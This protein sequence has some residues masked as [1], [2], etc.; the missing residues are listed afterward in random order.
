MSVN[1]R[2]LLRTI[3]IPT[4]ASRTITIPLTIR[5]ISASASTVWK[6]VVTSDATSTV[7]LVVPCPGVKKVCR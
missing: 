5:S 3:A 7:P 2:R 1:G 6:M 4:I